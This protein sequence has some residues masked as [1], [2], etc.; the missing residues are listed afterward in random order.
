[1]IAVLRATV[2]VV[3]VSIDRMSGAA[4]APDRYR[5]RETIRRVRPRME[6]NAPGH[7]LAPI[8]EARSRHGEFCFQPLR[9]CQPAPMRRVAMGSPTA[10]ATPATQGRRREA[11]AVLARRRGH[12][13]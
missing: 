13:G 9:P 7:Y 6:V 4:L 10:V 1:M 11:V 5:P 8:G 2:R 3:G 12:D